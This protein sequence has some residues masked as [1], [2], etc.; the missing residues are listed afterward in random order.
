MSVCI[1]IRS[2]CYISFVKY[3][4]PCRKCELS[5]LRAPSASAIKLPEHLRGLGGLIP[6]HSVL[7]DA[8]KIFKEKYSE[9]C[10][11]FLARYKSSWPALVKAGKSHSRRVKMWTTVEH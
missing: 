2:S 6:R 1:T 3:S 4:Q 10:V 8:M 7:G 11:V 9:P 5:S